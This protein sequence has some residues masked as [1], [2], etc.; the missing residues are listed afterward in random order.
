MHVA[1]AGGETAR[2]DH[3]VAL[4]LAQRGDY[5]LDEDGSRSG[6]DVFSSLMA[7]IVSPTWSNVVHIKTMHAFTAPASVAPLTRAYRKLSYPRTVKVAS[8]LINLGFTLSAMV[9]ALVRK[10]T[11]VRLLIVPA[12]M[13][14]CTS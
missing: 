7:P 11:I 12:A 13:A 1:S 2:I 6:I 8:D 9:Q 4:L 3:L 5:V 10:A 14:D